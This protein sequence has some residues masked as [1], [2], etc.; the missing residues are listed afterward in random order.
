M[1]NMAAIR[2]TGKAAAENLFMSKTLADNNKALF[3]HPRFHARP[4]PALWFAFLRE[5]LQL[6]KPTKTP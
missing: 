6:P 5:H 3:A 2:R 4:S 1:A